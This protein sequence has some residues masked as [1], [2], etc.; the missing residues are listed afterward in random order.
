MGLFAFHICIILRV[1]HIFVGFSC[2]KGFYMGFSL[3]LGKKG[4][5][6]R[7]RGFLW[8]MNEI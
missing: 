2:K 7:K 1:K 3:F 4:F 8:K 5:D 6:L